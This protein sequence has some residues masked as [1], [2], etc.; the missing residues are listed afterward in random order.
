MTLRSYVG[1]STNIL[2]ISP[3]TNPTVGTFSVFGGIFNTSLEDY[4]FNKIPYVKG[5]TSAFGNVGSTSLSVNLPTNSGGDLLI[6]F[7]STKS[8]S[9]TI[10][11][12]GWTVEAQNSAVDPTLCVLTKIS[13]GSEPSSYT[14]NITGGSA[15]CSA[16]I[17][18]LS[19][20]TS[21]TI[22][23]FG[24]EA[25]GPTVP[26][27]DDTEDEKLILFSIVNSGASRSWDISNISEF[28]LQLVNTDGPSLYVSAIYSLYSN[29]SLS[30]P[31]GQSGGAGN[32]YG[33]SV[34]IK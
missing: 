23:S 19:R 14:F 7:F 25:N 26:V 16:V 3:S 34:I 5:S 30:Y 31:T 20:Q 6:T 1:F 29:T 24:A 10:S 15:A 22:G 18:C 13:T 32:S 4:Y 33:I 21:Y 12:S 28:Q 27:P 2:A 9:R 11:S 8:L 17:V